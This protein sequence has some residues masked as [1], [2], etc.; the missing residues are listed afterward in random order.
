VIFFSYGIK[1][2]ILSISVGIMSALY[3]LLDTVNLYYES[4][5]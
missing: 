1:L 5:V 3:A 2:L 4:K